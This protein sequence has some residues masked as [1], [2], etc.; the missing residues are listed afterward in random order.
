MTRLQCWSRSHDSP[1]PSHNQMSLSATIPQPCWRRPRLARTRQGSVRS[2][3]LMVL[4][5]SPTPLGPGLHD[6]INRHPDRRRL[7]GELLAKRRSTYLTHLAHLLLDALAQGRQGRVVHIPNVNV[8]EHHTF[9]FTKA[10]RAAPTGLADC[11][12]GFSAASL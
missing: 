8:I 4:G 9:S 1:S 7:L 10:A 5:R 11:Q 3:L 6:L 12:A 2:C